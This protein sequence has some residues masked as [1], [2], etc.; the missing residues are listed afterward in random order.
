MTGAE[1]AE[2]AVLDS[3]AGA[4]KFIAEFRAR[5]PDHFRKEVAE[6][7][8]NADKYLSFGKA[9]GSQT[10]RGKIVILLGPPTSMDFEDEVLTT[11]AKRDSPTVAGFIDNMNAGNT[12]GSSASTSKVVRIIHFNYQGAIAKTADRK[13][14]DVTVEVDPVS[15]K[16]SIES[17]S[18][19]ADLD[20]IFEAV[21]QSW[22]RK[23]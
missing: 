5:R 18:Q 14:I 6:R 16:D 15:G 7:A 17:Y 10:L 9:R 22:I 1:R 11:Q 21:A 12:V 20:Q 2:W 3:D 8:K 13:S 23:P 4:E 19:E